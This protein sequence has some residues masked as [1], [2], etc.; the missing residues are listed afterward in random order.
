MILAGG[1]GV[2]AGLGMPKQL[3]RIAG[4]TIIEHTIQAVATSP[5]I[6]EIIVMMESDH[7]EPIVEILES[8]KFPKLTHVYRG[9][10]NSQRH[11][12]ASAG[13]AWR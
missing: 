3:A 4:K 13:Q 12:S 10:N 6:D 9:R 8:G 11:H 5:D 2:R 7:M 1:V